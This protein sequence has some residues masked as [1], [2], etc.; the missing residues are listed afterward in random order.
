VRAGLPEARDVP[1]D[2]GQGVGEGVVHD[3]VDV[4]VLSRAAQIV[5]RFRFLS[6]LVLVPASQMIL[7]GSPQGVEAPLVK[8]AL[9]T[10]FAD[11]VSP[12]IRAVPA[13]HD[14]DALDHAD[15]LSSVVLHEN[16]G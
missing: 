3:L 1:A 14:R 9:L 12:G 7:E 4:V 16:S 6:L 11:L 10:S 15:C 2:G 13:P 5:P 8:A